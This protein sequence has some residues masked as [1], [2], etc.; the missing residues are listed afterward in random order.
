M[1]FGFLFMAVAG[2]V[3]GA[4]VLVVIGKLLQLAWI[5]A[6]DVWWNIQKRKPKLRVDDQAQAFFVA[7]T[8][9]GS[10]PHQRHD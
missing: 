3:L 1:G 9:P 8:R 4:F 6:G 5:I 2:L 10:A 7:T